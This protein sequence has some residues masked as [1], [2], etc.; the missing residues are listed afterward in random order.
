MV[1]DFYHIFVSGQVREA[2]KQ[3]IV[4]AVA[5]PND[6]DFWNVFKDLQS[7]YFSCNANQAQSYAHS[8]RV[9]C[10]YALRFKDEIFSEQFPIK[11]LTLHIFNINKR[12]M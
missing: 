12:S 9:A 1:Q 5:N 3:N 2:V 11:D 4:G 6:E 7:C 8:E 10:L